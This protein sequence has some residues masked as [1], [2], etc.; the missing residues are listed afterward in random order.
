MSEDEPTQPMPIPGPDDTGGDDGDLDQAALDRLA[1]EL[2]GSGVPDVPIAEPASADDPSADEAAALAALSAAPSL[3]SAPPPPAP[4]ASAEPVAVPLDGG[5]PL[6][7][8]LDPED[9]AIRAELVEA[10]PTG[11]GADVELALANV[12]DAS[13]HRKVRDRALVAG[14][15]AAALL[16]VVIVAAWDRSGSSSDVETAG[17]NRAPATTA[18]PRPTIDEDIAYSGDPDQ[19]GPGTTVAPVQAAPIPSVSTSTV[20]SASSSTSTTAGGP[21]TSTSSPKPP[22]LHLSIHADNGSVKAGDRALFSV[23]VN[24]SGGDGTYEGNDC[25]QGHFKVT[26]APAFPGAGAQFVTWSGDPSTFAAAVGQGGGGFIP[27]PVQGGGGIGAV[28]YFS[29]CTAQSNPATLAAGASLSEKYAI[30]TTAAPGQQ[31]AGTYTVTAEFSAGTVKV[32]DSSSLNV[33]GTIPSLPGNSALQA[34]A[35]APSVN[36]WVTSQ[37]AGGFDMQTRY[38][39]G[40]WEILLASKGKQAASE[41]L[42]IRI[43]GS[44]SLVDVRAVSNWSAFSDDVGATYPVKGERKLYP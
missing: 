19:G 4:A 44:G 18:R 7:H 20:P 11:K 30:D 13:R 21:S 1:A 28:W 23:Q 6:D 5:T 25:G 12:K 34:V 41:I 10:V 39:R 9:A 17:D 32:T 33:T 36:A 24:N 43:D 14:G 31:V 27:R 40:A 29:A 26:V 2:D 16:L 15:I 37:P 42:R 22:D 35:T 3:S 8:H 38:Y